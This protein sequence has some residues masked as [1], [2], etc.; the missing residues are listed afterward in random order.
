MIAP[1]NRDSF[2]CRSLL[3]LASIAG[4]IS[5]DA[6]CDNAKR[7]WQSAIIYHASFP[8]WHVQTVGSDP[9]VGTPPGFKM[10]SHMSAILL[11]LTLEK[12]NS[13]GP[14]RKP[15]AVVLLS[16]ASGRS[17]CPDSCAA[18]SVREEGQQQP[19]SCVRESVSSRCLAQ[20][21]RRETPLP[22]S[23]AVE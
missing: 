9:G 4:K 2:R 8:S 7:A 11:M 3:K 16:R 10:R 20:R 12:N 14:V 13:G 21:C 23:Q 22:V 5:S 18:T 15:P 6:P 17:R 1:G 19:R